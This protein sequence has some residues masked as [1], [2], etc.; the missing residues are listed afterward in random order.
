MILGGKHWQVGWRRSRLRPTWLEILGLLL[1]VAGLTWA[2]KPLGITT[3][4]IMLV[5]IAQGL[6]GPPDEPAS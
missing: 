4:G 1:I 2:W 6:R 3:G 5:F